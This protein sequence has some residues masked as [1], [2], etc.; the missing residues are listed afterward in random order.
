MNSP[1][2]DSQK[3][4]VRREIQNAFPD[5]SQRPDLWSLAH[6]E[7]VEMRE[8]LFLI[9]KQDVP[10]YLKQILLDLLDTHTGV[11]ENDE[12]GSLVI[13]YLNVMGS[14]NAKTIREKFGEDGIELLL[15]KVHESIC[16]EKIKSRVD[17]QEQGAAYDLI[18]ALSENKDI[19]D[20][21]LNVKY[22]EN[23][24]RRHQAELFEDFSKDMASAICGWLKYARSWRDMEFDLKNIDSALIYWASRAK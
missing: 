6:D 9:K 8:D 24:L 1:A 13:A 21:L 19:L 16:G 4:V 7:C 12:N 10:Y 23:E 2:E 17:K 22:N 14:E 5:I 18:E 15:E 3:E 11:L 20:C